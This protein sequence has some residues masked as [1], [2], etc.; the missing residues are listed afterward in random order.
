MVQ[1]KD[2]KAPSRLWTQEEM[3]L[4]LD[5]Y[6]K[7]PFGRLNH[8]TPEVIQLAQLIGR[9]PSSVAY[10]LS[11]YA[12]CDPYIINSGRKGLEG[13]RDK[14]LPFWN[15]Y[16][17]RK[18]DLFILAA[19]LR[20]KLQ[21]MTIEQSL[22]IDEKNFLGL[23]RETLIKQRVNQSAFR[24]MVL[25]NYNHTCAVT[26]IDIPQLLI[27]SHIVPWAD[28]PEQRLNP[29]NGICLSPLY[30]KAFDKGFI[31]INTD[32]RIVLSDELKLHY[33]Q[34]YYEKHFA[35]VENQKIILPEEHRPDK[36]FLEY[37]L[38]NIFLHG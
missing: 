24:T 30:D 37:H 18:G 33:D 20:A 5:L 2:K 34:Q 35:V 17:Q 31:S 14:C 21:K 29:E 1:S 25:G 8:T 10:R 16:A 11:N 27:A 22:S 36:S 6:F 7:L 9:T 38:Q 4:A 3:I 23:E 13:G 19:K 26:G 12:S 15:D 28:N 32:Y